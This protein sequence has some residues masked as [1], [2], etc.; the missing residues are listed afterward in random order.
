MLPLQTL[1]E[2]VD[3]IAEALAKRGLDARPMLDEILDLDEQIGR[4]HV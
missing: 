4:A 1:R 3:R 2:D